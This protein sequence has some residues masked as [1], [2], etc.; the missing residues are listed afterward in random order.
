MKKRDS[1]VYDKAKYH[2]QS[3]KKEGLPDENAANHTVV[4]LRW[5]IENNLMSD[6]FINESTDILRRLRDGK[7]T[8]FEVYGFWDNCLIDE[9]LSA[10]GNLFAT[11]YFDFKN[12]QYANDYASKLKQ[13]LPTIFH[14]NYTEENYQAIRPVIDLRYQQWK[15]SRKPWW[16]IFN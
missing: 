12:G 2:I 14:I 9:M 11:Y 6:S 13:N 1:F 5:L 10:E 15:K 3:T 8:I 7:A 4:F 16:K